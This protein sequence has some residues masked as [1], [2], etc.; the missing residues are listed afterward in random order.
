MKK[1]SQFLGIYQ[2]R[3]RFKQAPVATICY[4]RLCQKDDGNLWNPTTNPIEQGA[5]A[6]STGANSK[7]SARLRTADFICVKPMETYTVSC[8]LAKVYVFEY[9]K[10]G[11][12]LNQASGWKDSPYTFTTG[13][14]TEN[15][16]LVLAA[17]SSGGGE[18][19]LDD[20]EWLH[21]TETATSATFA[22]RRPTEEIVDEELE[23]E[24]YEEE[25]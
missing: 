18:I 12:F 4:R 19:T 1:F 13:E 6:S 2:G 10:D 7:S 15:I 5:I 23:N 21:I 25:L 8:N 3:E 22:L 16:R 9:D 14:T 20:F 11:V 24:F 17:V